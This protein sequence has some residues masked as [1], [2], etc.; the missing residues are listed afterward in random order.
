ML[1]ETIIGSPVIRK[2]DTRNEK[3]PILHTLRAILLIDA[4]RCFEKYFRRQVF[5]FFS[6]A[7]LAIYVAVD[8]PDL[9]L[10]KPLK[11]AHIPTNSPRGK[12]N[13]VFIRML[14]CCP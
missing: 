7:N 14:P 3:Q 8:Q 6:I 4:T 9:L 11:F 12:H 13:P 5:G 2:S 10:I 1:W